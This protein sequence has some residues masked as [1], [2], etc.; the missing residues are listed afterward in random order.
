MGADRVTNAE[1]RNAISKVRD[2][3]RHEHFKTRVLVIVVGFLTGATR[4]AG[5]LG[6]VHTPFH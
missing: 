6:Y 3:Q 2:E 4:I 5:A 1:L